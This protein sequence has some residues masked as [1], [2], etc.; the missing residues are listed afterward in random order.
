MKI[1]SIRLQAL[2]LIVMAALIIPQTLMAQGRRQISA[3]AGHIMPQRAASHRDSLRGNLR[4]R[5]SVPEALAA[6]VSAAATLPS[7]RKAISL[8]LQE[9]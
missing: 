1:N 3:A 8:P 6:V 9:P 5:D 7:P 2:S 4:D